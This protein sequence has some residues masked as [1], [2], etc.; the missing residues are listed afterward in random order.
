[1]SGSARRSLTKP[2]VAAVASALSMLFV[3][4]GTE[5]SAIPPRA[6][7]PNAVPA[8]FPGSNGKIAFSSARDGDSEIF[9]MDADGTHVEQLTHNTFIDIT[10]RWSANGTKIA[11]TRRG[12]TE[13][14]STR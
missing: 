8:A 11:W 12:A 2:S 5:A 6:T 3:I 14:A 10:P 9:V 7:T 1:M 4:G 13:P